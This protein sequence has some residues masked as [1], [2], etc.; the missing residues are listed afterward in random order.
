MSIQE[1]IKSGKPFRRESWPEEFFVICKDP[2]VDFLLF[3]ELDPYRSIDISVQDVL[4]V[5]WYTR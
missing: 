1:A 3:M 2:D 4:A 5:D